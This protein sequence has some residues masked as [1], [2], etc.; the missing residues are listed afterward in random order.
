MRLI[1]AHAGKTSR[2]APSRTSRRV[3]PHSRG[4]NIKAAAA[5]VAEWGSSPLTRGKRRQDA[6]DLVDVGLI[7]ATRGKHT[8]RRRRRV[9]VGLIPT[10][11]GKTRRWPRRTQPTRVHPRSRGE[12]LASASTVLKKPG[13]SPLTRGKLVALRDD[14]VIAGLIPVHAGKTPPVSHPWP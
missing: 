7:P 5:V 12:N 10:H 11:A 1:P 14:R 8:R 9:R 2:P 6:R 13:S 3:H 4:E